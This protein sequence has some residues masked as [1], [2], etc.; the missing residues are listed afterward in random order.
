MS[1][2]EISDK[3]Y[4]MIEEELFDISEMCDI[5]EFSAL[6][7]RALY[8]YSLIPTSLIVED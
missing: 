8:D 3:L 1:K 6:F 7:Y 4:Q 2:K 5:G